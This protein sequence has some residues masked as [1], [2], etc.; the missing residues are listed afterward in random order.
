D[1]VHRS[2][3]PLTHAKTLRDVVRNCDPD[4]PLAS[5][6]PRWQ[7]FSLARGHEATFAL[8]KELEWRRSDRFVHA[9]LVSHR[10]AGKSTEILRLKDRLRSQYEPIF[11]EATV[12]MDP[13]HIEAEDL[14]LN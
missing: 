6:D 11:I 2:P 13:F 12:E 14:L 10:G 3:P 9:A 7:D 5:D 4:V 1:L 8:K